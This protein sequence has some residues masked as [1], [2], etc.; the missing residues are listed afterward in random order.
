MKFCLIILS[1]CL[2]ICF[3]ATPNPVSHP[4]D[5]KL[6]FFVADHVYLLTHPSPIEFDIIF[7][8]GLGGHGL[9]TW[10]VQGNDSYYW[11]LEWLPK[12][13]PQA[14]ILSMNYN[15]D[16]MEWIATP[17]TPNDK[18]K[19]LELELTSKG[20]IPD[21]PVNVGTRPLI[22]ITHSL[23]AVITKSVMNNAKKSDSI[24]KHKALL[25]QTQGII[26]YGSPHLSDDLQAGEVLINLVNL[27]QKDPSL[28]D[29][30]KPLSSKLVGINKDFKDVESHYKFKKYCFCENF[31][32]QVADM[33]NVMIVEDWAAKDECGEG[34]YST[35][36]ANHINLSKVEKEENL[37]KL[38]EVIKSMIKHA[39]DEL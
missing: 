1:I 18:S 14:R 19:N 39:K 16:I 21:Y 9:S 5:M 2:S 27:L 28:A 37:S 15:A 22:W 36:A 26:F 8:H 7:V 12:Y 20:P 10:S 17:S 13:F 35:I 32:T 38:V 6:P 30:L 23:G 24:E 31:P 34:H 29:E 11:I 3:G 25:K 33:M 4:P